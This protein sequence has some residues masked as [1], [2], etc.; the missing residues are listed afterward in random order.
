MIRRRRLGL[1]GLGLIAA[2]I[3]ALVVVLILG[4]GGQPTRTNSANTATGRG[5]AAAGGTTTPSP[6]PVHNRS[7]ATTTTN[8]AATAPTTAPAG[9]SNTPLR[10]LSTTTAQLPL[11]DSSRALVEDGQTLAPQRNLPTTVWLPTGSG[12]YPLVI[13]APGYSVGPATYA[14]FCSTLAASGY[15][16]AAPSFPLADPAQGHTLDEADLPNEAGDV[17]FVITQI[18]HGSL[19]DRIEPNEIAMVGHSDGA[20]VALMVGYQQ[21]S[22]DP[23]IKSVVAMAPD[24]MSGSPVATTRPLLLVQG[25]ADSVVPYSSSQRV[26]GQVD[27][28]RYYVTLLGADHFPPI[29]GGTAWTPVLDS[30]VADFLDAT[31]AGRGPGVD[32]LNQQ[33]ASSS[34]EQLQTAPGP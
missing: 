24:P 18:L 12:P 14:R 1:A 11:V 22:I 9:R 19:A 26:F 3:A 7:S 32:A 4:G 20:D 33:L 17:S 10:G 6:S 28:P 2:A 13:F 21:G 16:V 29:G 5:H 31:V 30:D 34:L 25:N 23:R 8:G 15:V 27:A